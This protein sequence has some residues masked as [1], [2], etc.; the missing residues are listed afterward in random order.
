M[1]GLFDLGMIVVCPGLLRLS[2]GGAYP[3]R[4]TVSG[5]WFPKAR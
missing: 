1:Q 3:G 4:R 5:S 2:S